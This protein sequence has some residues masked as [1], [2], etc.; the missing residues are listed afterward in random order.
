MKI[1]EQIWDSSYVVFMSV[2][3]KNSTKFIGMLKNIGVIWENKINARL[4]VIGEHK[5]TVDND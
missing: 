3:N 5:T 4:I 1:S 2:G